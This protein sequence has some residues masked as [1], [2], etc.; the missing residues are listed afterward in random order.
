[1]VRMTRRMIGSLSAR[2]SRAAGV[3]R[4]PRGGSPGE[5]PAGRVDS[6]LRDITLRGLTWLAAAAQSGL[7]AA[8]IGIQIAPW[9]TRHRTSHRR[10]RVTG[11]TQHGP[12]GAGA[13]DQG[14]DSCRDAQP[15]LRTHH[16]GS[17]SRQLLPTPV[18][19]S[20]DLHHRLW[21]SGL[22]EFDNLRLPAAH[23]SGRTVASF[24]GNFFANKHLPGYAPA[25]ISMAPA[26]LL[27]PRG[28][29]S[30]CGSAAAVSRTPRAPRHG[31]R[32]TE[33]KAQKSLAQCGISS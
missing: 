12:R 28:A 23:F 6:S 27:V 33:G 22:R 18:R 17:G 20:A 13:Q 25:T 16:G 1:M 10:R 24:P 9:W 8:L 26:L 5:V 7:T 29:L 4:L 21:V 32:W 11:T 3:T 2:C 19:V 30:T 14:P 15:R 31:A